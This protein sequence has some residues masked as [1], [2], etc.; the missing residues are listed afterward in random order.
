MTVKALPNG[1]HTVTPYLVVADGAK[2]IEFMSA[3]FDARVT[4]QLMRP[5][6]TIWHAEIRVGDSMIMLSESSASAPPTPVMLHVYVDDVDTV[7]KRAV[8][9]GGTVVSA[10]TDQF[11]GD[12]S[13]GIREPSGNTLWIAT[14]I[15][16]VAPDELQRRAAQAAQIRN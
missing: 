11:Y 12:R 2:F 14:H 9:A 7:F 16:D 15:E 13:C 3:V 8:R 5:D 4:E 10:P 6:A 1:Y